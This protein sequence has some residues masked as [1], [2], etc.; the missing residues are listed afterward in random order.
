MAVRSNIKS[1]AQFAEK[2]FLIGAAFYLSCRPFAG[3]PNQNPRLKVNLE[4]ASGDF[5]ISNVIKL[6]DFIRPRRQ[7]DREEMKLIAD[8]LDLL[9]KTSEET[10]ALSTET[11]HE[12]NK[13]LGLA[14]AALR[15]ARAELEA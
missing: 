11:A 14:E 7:L 12:F 2:P 8:Y 9:R 5:T 6:R 1:I 13:A 4:Q 15:R 3:Q 10:R